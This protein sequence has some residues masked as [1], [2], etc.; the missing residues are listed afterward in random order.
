[1]KPETEKRLAKIKR[2]SNVLRTICKVLLALVTCG[3]LVA[4][5]A[6]FVGR[7]NISFFDESVPL[8]PL[9]LPARL[10]LVVITAF[11]MAVAFRGFY[12][13]YRLLGNYGRGDI[14]TIESAGHIRQL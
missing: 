4:M 1:M 5:V 14:F 10:L 7:G 3:F 6:L 12:H 11:S 2:I 9:T 8:T 13:L